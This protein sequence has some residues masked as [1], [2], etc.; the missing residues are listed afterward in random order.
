MAKKYIRNEGDPQNPKRPTNEK[1]HERI[2]KENL[3]EEETGSSPE[4]L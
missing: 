4:Q 3:M 2:E 1:D